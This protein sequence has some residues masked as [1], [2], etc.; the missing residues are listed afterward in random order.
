MD[1][2]G[3]IMVDIADG[4]GMV[5]KVGRFSYQILRTLLN[6]FLS[7]KYVK[8][9]IPLNSIQNVNLRLF[10]ISIYSQ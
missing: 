2:T 6:I 7:V 3:N 10:N 5:S 8:K 4:I 9:Y 1:T